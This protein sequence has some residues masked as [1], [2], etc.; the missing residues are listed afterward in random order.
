MSEHDLS[1]LFQKC[2]ELSGADIVRFSASEDSIPGV[3]MGANVPIAVLPTGKQL[4][5]MKKFIDE[6]RAVPERRRSSL[7]LRDQV[8]FTAMVNRNKTPAT[9]ILANDEGPALMAILDYHAVGPEGTPGWCEDRLT[10]ALETST[11]W[12]VW[13]GTEGKTYSVPEFSEF[14]EE[15]L[16][17]VLDPGAAGESTRE[18]ASKMGVQLATPANLLTLSKGLSVRQ[19]L[20]VSQAVNTATGEA[21]ISF[22]QRNDPSQQGMLSVPGAFV[23]GIPVFYNGPA[24]QI[25]VRLRYRVRESRLS[26]SLVPYRLEKAF[27]HAFSEAIAQVAAATEVTVIRGKRA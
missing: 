18:F 7:V 2:S 22:E 12:G 1:E 25:P 26:W 3:P 11:E 5:S 15:H 20:N 23:I 27:E 16:V 13:K 6:W 24:Y 9:I 10:Y 4:L 19:N 21:Q 8:S 14:I 17:D